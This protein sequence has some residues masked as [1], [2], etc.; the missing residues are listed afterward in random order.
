MY[1]FLVGDGIHV[2]QD[3][4]FAEME[5]MKQIMLLSAPAAGSVHFQV[6]EGSS[7]GTGDLVATLDLDTPQ[8]IS[9]ARPFEG[10]WPLLS[11]P[12]V[13]SNSLFHHFSDAHHAADMLLAGYARDPPSVLHDLVAIL[14]N[15]DLPFVMWEDHMISLGAVLPE[16]LNSELLSIVAAARSL[17]V[18]TDFPAD[19]LQAKLRH[20]IAVAAVAEQ[21]SLEAAMA[22]ALQ[23]LP[24]LVGGFSH[25]IVR[26]ML[27]GFV[28][29]EAPF[30][31]VGEADTVD[32]LRREHASN[33]QLVLDAL[34]SHRALPAKVNFLLGLL[35]AEVA[36]EPQSFEQEL[37][38]VAELPATPP[39]GRLACRAQQL[40]EASLLTELCREISAALV[41][42]QSSCGTW[43]TDQTSRQHT[44]SSMGASGSREASSGHGG[45]RALRRTVAHVAEEL[46][47]Q[48]TLEDKC[49]PL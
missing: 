32:K 13:E 37:M 24:Q 41:P 16:A 42:T 4:P 1:R 36:R 3:Q 26:E 28:R 47:R 45:H 10:Q 27:E 12:Q 19:E 39:L 31:A 2:E 9:C 46:G 35:N 43:A 21:R 38:A 15:P 22:R 49:G 20:A 7:L 17:E 34:V 40:L 18:H 48:A 29:F 33:L 14:A 6:A 25:R 11:H 8:A 44:G 30:A 5:A 23:L